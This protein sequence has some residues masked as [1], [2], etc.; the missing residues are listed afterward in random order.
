MGALP[1]LSSSLPSS[2]REAEHPVFQA[3]NSDATRAKVSSPEDA[4]D[5]D[6][7][8]DKMLS[9]AEQSSGPTEQAKGKRAKTKTTK[10]MKEV[11]KTV[12]TKA[13][14]K[15]QHNR[16]GA[17]VVA[18]LSNQLAAAKKALVEKD[19]KEKFKTAQLNA[20]TFREDNLHTTG[21]GGGPGKKKKKAHANVWHILGVMHAAFSRVKAWAFSQSWG[22]SAAQVV[23][24]RMV[25]SGVIVELQQKL[26]RE[27]IRR[28]KTMAALLTKEK[29]M[30]A[31]SDSPSDPVGSVPSPPPESLDGDYDG[32]PKT[33]DSEA[34]DLG[35]SPPDGDYRERPDYIFHSQAAADFASSRLDDADAKPPQTSKQKDFICSVESFSGM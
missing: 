10:P 28:V 27:R 31:S 1:T 18:R 6:R 26:Y 14:E 23:D 21:E 5:V 24:A 35:S 34:N 19:E 17:A 12:K 22:V 9:S 20:M 25:I 16:A 2:E 15:P 29:R 32:M 11:K 4:S 13:K 30:G 7:I 8:L 33:S 3:S